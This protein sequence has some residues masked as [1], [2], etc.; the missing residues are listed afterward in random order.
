MLYHWLA[1]FSLRR[2]TLLCSLLILLS[3]LSTTLLGMRLSKQIDHL[4]AEAAHLNHIQDAL[5]ALR[6]HTSQI[7]Q[8]LTD[9]SLT[10]DADA[11]SEARSHQ[12]AAQ[13]LLPTVQEEKIA[14]QGLME[15]QLR[16][17][18]QMVQ[19]Y[20][21]QGAQAGNALMKAPVQGFD[22]I[23]ANIAQQLDAAL[24]QH[25]AEL[26]QS[27][28]QR[29]A[30]E[31][32]LSSQTLWLQ[33]INGLL[34]LLILAA[35]LVKVLTPLK[36]L[37]LN[38]DNL[39]RGNKNLAFRLP[40]VGQDEFARLAKTFNHFL[41]DLDHI[42]GT[43][44]GVSE[45]NGHKIEGLKQ[46]TRMTQSS[47][48]QVQQNTDAL[49]TAINEM[50]ST[51]QEIAR[52]TDEAKQE[53]EQTQQAASMG[54]QRVAQAV[55]LI[56]EVA[57]EIEQAAGII[58]RLEQES[59]QIGEILNVIRTISDQT[60]L[61][62]LNAAIEAARAGEAGRGFAVVAD[63]VR[64]L[65]NRT[66]GATVEIQQKIE[67]LQLR[68]AEAVNTMHET[69]R[70]SEQAV[71]QASDAG[72]TLHAI[73]SA[74]D[75]ITGLNTQI[76]AAAE[77]QS[78]VAE[79]TSRNVV[80]VADIARQ[81][82]E[83]AHRSARRAQEVGFGSEEIRLL[84]S[85]FKVSYHSTQQTDGNIVNWSPAFS[86]DVAEVDGQ[87]K[88]LFDAMNHFYR[89]LHD[90]S[91]GHQIKQRLD[92]LVNLA[93]QHLISE[94]ALMHKANYSDLSGHKEVHVKLLKDLDALLQRFARGEPDAD[95]EIVMFLKSWLIDHIFRVDKHYVA[96]L[97]AA[98]IR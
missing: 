95:L 84:G 41:G 30:L 10:G 32:T 66:Q 61:L 68:T 76:A 48:D 52:N 13:A 83:L 28:Q 64:M 62:A 46:Q 49:A 11:V 82:L 17:G 69:S 14:L 72:Q 94:E 87:H 81:T 7:Q 85:Q 77:E 92:H 18:L 56:Q 98:G 45:Q 44:Q 57:T 1:R 86:V 6:F 54:Q 79:E 89:A 4:G 93:K 20:Q 74:V 63:E 5:Q 16:V 96:E 35:L 70:L 27:R 12:A 37:A 88:G 51:V 22:A 53:T 24:Q 21:Q 15:Q 36:A 78:L 67:Q 60:N 71:L 34:V 73:V 25:G 59:G 26:A 55:N 19:A 9:A 8:F 33:G 29:L 47:M 50:A 75:R 31:Q 90:G 80:E 38:L 23:S 42:V 40:V 3:I 97:H 43:V 2:F 39:A 58:N 65:A 91:A